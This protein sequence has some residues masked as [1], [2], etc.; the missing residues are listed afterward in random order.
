MTSYLKLLRHDRRRL[1]SSMWAVNRL[2]ARCSVPKRKHS[3]SKSTH[4]SRRSCRSLPSRVRTAG[5]S[6]TSALCVAVSS[7]MMI[8]RRDSISVEHQLSS[9]YNQLP[10]III[11]NH[12]RFYFCDRAG[13]MCHHNRYSRYCIPCYVCNVVRRFNHIHRRVICS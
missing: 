2:C 8:G 5:I 11:M 9:N 6:R 7:L 1:G 4:G 12:N 10:L 3:T 13:K